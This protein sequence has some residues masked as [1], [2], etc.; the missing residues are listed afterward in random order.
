MMKSEAVVTRFRHDDQAIC[1]VQKGLGS[2][3]SI[4]KDNVTSERS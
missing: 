1:H 3:F 4:P 2:R